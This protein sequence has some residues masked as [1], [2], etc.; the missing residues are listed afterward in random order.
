MADACAGRPGRGWLAGQLALEPFDRIAGQFGHARGPLG[1]A[2]V[3]AQQ[4]AVVL[5]HHAAAGCVDQDGLDTLLERGP[6]GVDV[7]PGR[8]ERPALVGKMM[9]Q[10]AAAAGPG[11]DDG[12]GTKAVQD[13]GSRPID[14]RH[15]RTLGATVEQQYPFTMTPR[16]PVPAGRD[17]GT[18]AWIGGGSSGRTRRASR[19]AGSNSQRRVNVSR[20][21]S[22]VS[23]S[24]HG[25]DTRSSTS[26][27]PTSTRWP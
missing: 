13:P 15:H 20:N 12:L 25:R 24:R 22:R 1:V 26:L 17:R 9:A 2:G 4:V 8:G 11:G 7:A 19:I 16:R 3:V 10:R 14:C 5:D 6:P 21:A 23:R 27:R 18:L